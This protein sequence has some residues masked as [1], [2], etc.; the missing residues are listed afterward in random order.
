MIPV[1]AMEGHSAAGPWG[2]LGIG[3]PHGWAISPGNALEKD[4]LAIKS[5]RDL[6]RRVAIITKIMKPYAA[7]E[8]N[9]FIKYHDEYVDTHE[10][11]VKATK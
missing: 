4:E 8:R 3:Y 1:G 11:K 9:E 2:G 5:S 7:T 6:G 10:Y